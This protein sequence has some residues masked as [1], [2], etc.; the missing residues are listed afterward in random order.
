VFKTLALDA[1]IGG[2]PVVGAATPFEVAKGGHAS[3]EGCK[4]AAELRHYRVENTIA[5]SSDFEWFLR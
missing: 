1:I 5:G 3:N 2:P 4:A